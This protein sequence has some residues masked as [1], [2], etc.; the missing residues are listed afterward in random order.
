MGWPLHESLD[1]LPSRYKSVSREVPVDA[2]SHAIHCY[3]WHGME[4]KNSK[5]ELKYTR[6]CHP[7]TTVR[8]N[9]PPSSDPDLEL[10]ISMPIRHKCHPVDI[11]SESCR[12]RKKKRVAISSCSSQPDL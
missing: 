1:H 11:E 6:P 4:E 8:G 12:R 10:C 2:L 9:P 5:H 3:P 7:P